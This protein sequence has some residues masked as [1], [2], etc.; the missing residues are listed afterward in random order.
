VKF[1]RAVLAGI[2]SGVLG[3][4][5]VPEVFSINPSAA[6]SGERVTI[7]GQ[8]FD[9][10]ATNNAVFFGNVR[11][12]VLG[13]AVTELSVE[14]PRGVQAGPV[15]VAAGALLGMS[16]TPFLP[17]FTPFTAEINAVY[18]RRSNVLTNT[19]YAPVSSGDLDGDGDAELISSS[20]SGIAGYV[21]QEAGP[22]ISS[23]SFKK[24]FELSAPVQLGSFLLADID[25]DGRL[26]ILANR[27]GTAALYLFRNIHAGGELSA[28]SFEKPIRHQPFMLPGA[29]HTAD[30]DRD[31]RMDFV[32]LGSAGVTLFRNIYSPA[33]TNGFLAEQV[34]ILRAE[35]VGIP[36]AI[37]LGDLN[38]DGHL[39]IAVLAGS[40]LLIF[41][42][43]DRPGTLTT[44]SFSLLHFPATN[45]TWLEIGDVQGDGFADI[46][47]HSRFTGTFSVLWNQNKGGRL[48]PEDFRTVSILLRLNETARPKLIDVNGD[49][50]PDLVRGSGWYS[51]NESALA[52]GFVFPGSFSSA[53][54]LGSDQS[55]Q[56]VFPADVN[57]DGIPELLTLSSGFA[58]FQNAWT[59]DAAI[60][61]V[62]PVWNGLVM[63]FVGKPGA[64]VQIESSSDLSRWASISVF[65]RINLSGSA[66]FHVPVERKHEF[67]RVKPGLQR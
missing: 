23:N 38:R 56:E 55:V 1:S 50:L 19:P 30:I 36:S 18:V 64:P 21:Y 22:L 32:T 12:R 54:S 20:R 11:A 40:D 37:S 46:V 14:V 66:S 6:R 29:V 43:N 10:V 33:V 25:S 53:G 27:V 65:P 41:S 2:L 59:L 7:R 34:R 39:E 9:P 42:H 51:R 31:G 44:N 48:L 26:D 8:D 5:Q 17:L 49:A 15:T 16:P 52:G 60:D 35:E 45:V 13:A 3:H 57:G 67:F 47:M 61:G 4:A 24:V 58:V 63:R 28:R 62:T